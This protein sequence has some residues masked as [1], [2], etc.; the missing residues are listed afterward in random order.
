MVADAWATALMTM[1]YE[2]GLEFLKKVKGVNA[3]WVLDENGVLK[4]KK[5]GEIKIIDSIYAISDY[6]MIH[7]LNHIFPAPL[8]KCYSLHNYLGFHTNQTMVFY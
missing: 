4:I 2:K 5:Y 1:E 7:F 8:H 3:L 6:I